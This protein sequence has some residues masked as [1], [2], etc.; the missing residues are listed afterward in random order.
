MC[1]LLPNDNRL[2]EPSLLFDQ[3]G[4]RINHKVGTEPP[5]HLDFLK[6]LLYINETFCNLS[7]MTSLTT[8]RQGYLF[9]PASTFCGFCSTILLSF[10]YSFFFKANWIGCF[11]TS[12]CKL[13]HLTLC[14]NNKLS[15]PPNQE[16]QISSRRMALHFQCHA[17]GLCR[18]RAGTQHEMH[19]LS[20]PQ[21]F[22]L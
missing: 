8:F 10:L 16:W 1:P 14:N 20:L 12:I 6:K 4:L 21:P 5:W 3:I 19:S 9:P 2:N 11:L 13:Q 17:H 22:L 18:M 15:K 7:E